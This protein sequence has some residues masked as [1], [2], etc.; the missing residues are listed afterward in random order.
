VNELTFHSNSAML[1][2]RSWT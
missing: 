2:A 1:D